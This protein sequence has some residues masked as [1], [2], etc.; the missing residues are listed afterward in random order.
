MKEGTQLE[1]KD[2][3]FFPIFIAATLG[4]VLEIIAILVDEIVVGNLFTDESFASVN[5]IEPYT[6]FETF[7][8]Y[9][10]S[11]GGA[12]LIVRA[13]GAGDYEKMN[14][15]FSQTMILCAVFGIGLTAIYV[16]FTPQLVQFVADD[17]DVYQDAFDYFTYM[18]FYPLVDIFDT[19][20][21]TYV[22]Y[23]G[24][25][26]HFYVAIFA[27]IGL[28]TFLSWQLGS[29]MGLAGI[30]L[31]SIISLL[32]AVLIKMTF[33]F[34]QKHGLE[35]KLYFNLREA[36]SIAWLGFP[37]SA[38][39][40]FIVIMELIVNRFTLRSYGAA[41]VAAV[42]VLINIFEFA[43]Y[44]S[45]GLSEYVIVSVNDSIGKLSSKSMDRAIKTTKRAALIEGAV[46]IALVVLGANVL[47]EAFDIDNPE[48]ASLATSMLYILAP[49]AIF[50]CLTRVTAIYY[51]Y[52][53]RIPRTILLFGMAIAALPSV[54]TLVLGQ[55]S[56]E[57]IAVGM[58]LGPFAAIALMYLYVRFVKKEK[59]FDYSN[60]HLN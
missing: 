46:L 48:T 19:F 28:N 59:L 32:V 40:M 17:P 3:R 13:R 6:Y 54:F 47:P 52:T 18:R 23:R 51:Q 14:N 60:M 15:L 30:G 22:L 44:L 5:L 24:G 9:L 37:E 36:L 49:T 8:A 31:A 21:F 33:L 26:I 57:G 10:I 1:K 11:V 41:G 12:A 55:I 45:E 16:I 53:K 43:F 56:I 39:S 20:F 58:T 7:L 4:V 34:S 25:Y 35:F 2:V 50:I 27:R 42:A 29:V 38:L